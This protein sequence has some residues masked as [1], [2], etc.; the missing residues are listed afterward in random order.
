HRQPSMPYFGH[1]D[2]LVTIEL[3]DIDVVGASTT[4]R[5]RNR[6]AGAG[7]GA[8]EHAVN[9]NTVPRHIG[10][11][12]HYL[13]V[14]VGQHGHHTLHPFRVLRERLYLEQWLGLGTKAGV[15]RAIGAARLPSLTGLARGE[16]GFGDRCDR[17]HVDSLFN[18]EASTATSA[19]CR[20]P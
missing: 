14:S 3:H 7:M 5:R 17:C 18:A 8:M 16:E 9:G 10:G 11:E 12:R 15:G 19:W 2:D 1:V 13:V 6:A 20:S 4:S